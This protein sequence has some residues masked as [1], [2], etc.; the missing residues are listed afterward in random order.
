[1]GPSTVICQVCLYPCLW[2]M[3]VKVR[4]LNTIGILWVCI[5]CLKEEDNDSEPEDA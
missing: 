5:R 4:V 3:P 1:M 2:R